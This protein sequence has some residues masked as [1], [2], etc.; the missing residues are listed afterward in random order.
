M[1]EEKKYL[2]DEV[3]KHLNKSD[4][5][6]VADYSRITVEETATLRNSLAEQ[7]A[8]FHVVKNSIFNVA[9]NERGM[10]ISEDWLAGPTAIII[11]GENPPGVAKVLKKFF[12]DKDKVQVKGGVLEAVTLTDAQVSDLADLPSKE[13]LQAKLLGLLMQPGTMLVRLLNTPGSQLAT[14]LDRRRE[15]LAESA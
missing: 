13:E 5:C 3:A 9:A 7:G 4:Y 11:G 15:Q 12:K 2:V 1:R 6:F 10:P 14:V 8:E